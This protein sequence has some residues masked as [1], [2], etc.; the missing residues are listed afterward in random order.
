MEKLTTLLLPVPNT[1]SDSYN[2]AQYPPPYIRCLGLFLIS[3]TS[4]DYPAKL[5]LRRYRMYHFGFLTKS[6][7]FRELYSSF[8]T[9]LNGTKLLMTVAVPEETRTT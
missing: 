2:S 4:K 5:I 8:R 3:Y 7:W 9:R 6:V 1:T